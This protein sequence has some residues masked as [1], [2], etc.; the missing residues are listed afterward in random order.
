MS[1]DTSENSMTDSS[2]SIERRVHY[3]DRQI[4]LLEIR[5]ETLAKSIEKHME[6]NEN[7]FSEVIALLREYK[8]IGDAAVLQQKFA[9]G[10]RAGKT[11]LIP[12]LISI[13][14]LANAGLVTY[15]VLTK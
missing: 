15:T 8:S 5:H 6:A 12:V 10:F 9:E 13:L 3:L 2:S 4:S 1:Q 11:W 7:K 14:V